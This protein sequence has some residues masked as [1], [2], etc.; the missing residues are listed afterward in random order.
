MLFR[1]RDV[2]LGA[3]QTG[4]LIGNAVA[5]GL[6]LIV[7]GRALKLFHDSGSIHGRKMGVEEPLL[8]D[9]EGSGNP[10]NDAITIAGVESPKKK[11]E[12]KK[13]EDGKRWK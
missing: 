8:N 12:E 10:I 9:E 5:C 11:T 7:N 6:L 4:G 1:D 13:K 3:F 2:P